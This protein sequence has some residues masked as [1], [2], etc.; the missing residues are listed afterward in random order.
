LCNLDK[1]TT[2]WSRVFFLHFNQWVFWQC[3]QT[4]GW[5]WSKEWRLESARVHDSQNLSLLW[6]IYLQLTVES[7]YTNG[8]T[9]AWTQA[10]KTLSISKVSSGNSF[11]WPRFLKFLENLNKPKAL[12]GIYLCGAV[13]QFVTPS[14]RLWSVYKQKCS[15]KIKYQ[16]SR[17]CN[18]VTQRWRFVFVSR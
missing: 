4:Q 6:L 8:N 7:T 16:A 10:N 1:A 5:Y 12:F 11:S 18:N 3:S 17:A 9:Q 2:I 15:K 13:V 14:C